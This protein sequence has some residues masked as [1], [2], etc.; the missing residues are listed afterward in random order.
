[1]LQIPDWRIPSRALKCLAVAIAGLSGIVILLDLVHG[2]TF[3]P[4]L[5]VSSHCPAVNRENK[6]ARPTSEE[7]GRGGQGVYLGVRVA[8]RLHADPDSTTCH[9]HGS[10]SVFIGPSDFRGG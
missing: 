2:E 4:L 10:E 8:V 5:K 9:H 6:K 7:A 1:M 3:P